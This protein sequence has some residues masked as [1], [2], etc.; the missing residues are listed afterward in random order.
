MD[1]LPD[2]V[3]WSLIGE[4]EFCSYKFFTSLGFLCKNSLNLTNLCSKQSCPI[5]N[6]K[7]ATI[8]EKSGIFFLFKKE[9]KNLNFPNKMWKKNSFI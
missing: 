9:K 5:S 7:Y 3:I 2:Q 1:E 4:K 8:V 6:S